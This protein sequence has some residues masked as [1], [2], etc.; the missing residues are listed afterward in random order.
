MIMALGAPF[1]DAYTKLEEYEWHEHNT[2]IS[3][4]E[5]AATMDCCS[6]FGLQA[7]GRIST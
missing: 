4:W 1:V 7:P 2:H 6:G 5:R 3:A